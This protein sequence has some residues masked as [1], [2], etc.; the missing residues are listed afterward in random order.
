MISSMGEEP[1]GIAVDAV[2]SW[3]AERV[4]W[5]VPPLRFTALE[6]GH[7][8]FTYRVEDAEGHAFVLRRPPLGE[9]LPTAHDMGREYRL[10]SALWPTPV[11]VPEPVAYCDDISITGAPFFAMGWVEGRALYTDVDVTEHLTLQARAL[12]GPSFIQTLADLH[13]LDPDA[14]GL[15]DLGKHENYVGRQIR[16]WYASWNASKN[17]EIPAVD[18]LHD[19]LEQHLPQQAT[20]AVV[21]GDYGLHNCRVASAGHIAAVV[22]WEI[23]TLGD[24]LA[25][26]AY[27]VNAWV[28]PGERTASRADAPTQLPGFCLRADLLDRYQ[29]RTG[30]DLTQI[31]Y[32]RAFNHFKTAGI[33]QGV[34]ARYLAG[35]KSIDAAELAEWPERIDR[36]ID[37]AVQA[38]TELGF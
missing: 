8:N 2:T 7:S 12:T 37:L 24:P 4:H 22:D 10:I 34:Y 20:V 21:H 17:R 30:A 36:T 31:A 29:Q 19:W 1:T 25:D 32:Y 33:L 23:S 18:R 28:E 26:L 27:C 3:L 15:G 14:V 35:Q 5:L 13:A 11:P 6:G 9:L 38:A 16:R